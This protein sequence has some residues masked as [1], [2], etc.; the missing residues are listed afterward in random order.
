METESPASQVGDSLI[1]EPD[2]IANPQ[3]VAGGTLSK[4]GSTFPKSLNFYLD[5]WHISNEITSLMF[6]PLISLHSTENR[7]IGVLAE[8]WN[9]SEDN[10]TFTFKIHPKAVWS[11]GTPITAEDIQFHYDVIMN[12]KNLTPVFRVGLKRFK[13]PEVI[14]EKTISITAHK[15][16]WLNFY[17][18]GSMVAFPKHIWKDVDFNKQNFEFPIVSGPYKIHG[19]VKK[20]RTVTLIRRNDWWGRCLKYN[21]YKYNFDKIKYK[22]MNDQNKVLE[23]FKRGDLD[24]YAVYTS[25]IWV[26]KTNF[27]ATKKGWVVRQKIYNQEPKSFQG[28][29]INLRKPKFQDKRV[30]LA[31]CHLL[32][33]ELMNEKLMFNEYFLLNSYFPDLFPDNTNPNHPR[34]EYNPDRARALLKE[35]GWS[36][37]SNGLLKKDGSV[38]A[39][40]F[41]TA[42]VEFRHLNVYIE[43][44][45]K[46]GIKAEIEQ[47]S[48]STVTKRLDNFEFDMYW[49]NTGASRLRDSE[50]AWHSKTARDKASFNLAGVNDAVVD[51][52]IEAQKTEVDMDKRNEILRALD[53]R[54]IEIIPT[55]LLWQAVNHRLL[56]WNKFGTPTYVLDRFNREDVIVAY[57]WLDKEKEA[58]LKAAMEKGTTLPLLPAEITYSE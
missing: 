15:F 57:W 6:E 33:R 17:E 9:V 1:G 27:P 34:I 25:S 55:A 11:D 47:A 16:H 52:L 21:Q 37:G 49:R 50:S 39:I 54:L 42:S 24:I 3:A 8:S 22:F 23:A 19:K 36:V 30:R 58:K 31:L 48:K 45:K 18:A 29:F 35:A 7:P 51:S 4:W 40:T 10:M 13:R 28:L 44:L 41:L 32:N 43:D 14:D 2:P 53:N 46:V 5:Q 26:K 20:G 56:Y 38:F 12:P